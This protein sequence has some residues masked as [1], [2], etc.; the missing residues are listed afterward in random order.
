MTNKVEAERQAVAQQS[1]IETAQPDKAAMEPTPQ[2]R[3]L[4]ADTQ[5]QQ[6][7]CKAQ[8]N[9]RQAHG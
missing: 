7:P 4:S 5:L 9:S 3:W 8:I 6:S 2:H 1:K